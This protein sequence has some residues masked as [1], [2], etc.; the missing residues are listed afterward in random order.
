MKEIHMPFL[1]EFKDALNY[2]QKCMTT[3]T[4]RYGEVGDTF[5]A[6]GTHFEIQ[7]IFKIRLWRIA[8]Q[9]YH[10]E[11]FSTSQEFINIWNRLHRN[12][13]EVQ[14]QVHFWVH[15]FTPDYEEKEVKK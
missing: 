1:P 12:G 8:H 11:G 7:A 13:Y 15:I 5:T 3:R 9:F 10:A 14:Q 2:G 6:F 4:E